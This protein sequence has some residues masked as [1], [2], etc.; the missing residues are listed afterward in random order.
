MDQ[1]CPNFKSECYPWTNEY[2]VLFSKPGD[3]TADLDIL[4][5][6]N[7]NSCYCGAVLIDNKYVWCCTMTVKDSSDEE[8]RKLLLSEIP[9]EDN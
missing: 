9:S 1:K 2:R 3:T 5:H 6:Y 8:D 4:S 7:F